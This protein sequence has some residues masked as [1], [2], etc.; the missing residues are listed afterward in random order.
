M[1]QRLD[2]EAHARAGM[3]ALGG[4]HMFVQ[5]ARLPKTLIDLAYLRAPQINGC[6]YCID[7]HAHD[8]RQ[9]VWPTK[10]CYSSRSGERPGP[11]SPTANVRPWPGRKRSR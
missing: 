8:L 5:G 2:Y 3:R 1:T 11:G 9:R 4:V 10:S 6:S 7:S